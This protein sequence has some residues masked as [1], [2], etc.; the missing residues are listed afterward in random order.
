[1][2]DR[3][4]DVGRRLRSGARA[5]RLAVRY[6]AGWRLQLTFGPYEEAFDSQ[7]VQRVRSAIEAVTGASPPDGAEAERDL[8]HLSVSWRGGH[9]AEA[10][11]TLL[12]ELVDALG[13]PASQRD[14]TQPARTY[15]SGAQSPQVTHWIWKDGDA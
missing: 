8:W 1:M 12:A 11:R 2:I 13:V 7:S 4:H 15:A 6:W 5:N 3:P 10:A 14:G 9:P